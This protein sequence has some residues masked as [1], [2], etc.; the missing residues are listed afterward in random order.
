M[1]GWIIT[2]S[3]LLFFIFLMI[4]PVYLSVR[5]GDKNEVTA[6]YLFIK[7]PLYPRKPKERKKKAGAEDADSKKKKKEKAKA[8][9]SETIE[10][11]LDL[12]NASASPLFD[13]LRR[14]YLVRF[15]LRMEIGGE[16]AAAIALN[17]VRIQAAVGYFL[18]LFRS[19]R[20]L[21]RLRKVSI[22]PNFLR[23]DIEYNTRFCIMIRLSTVLYAVLVAVIR[24]VI[25]KLQ[26]EPTQEDTP[27]KPIDKRMQQSHQQE[28]VTRNIKK[29]EDIDYGT[30][31]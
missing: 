26:K 6:G 30:S 2:G 21:K 15:G 4:A 17:T 31:H 5:L 20:L 22:V 16:D 7:I 10:L 28:K 1:T 11:I 18:G 19:L 29:Q 8:K 14:T 12:A 3:I 25:I 24:F 27:K 23:E 13:L 9:A